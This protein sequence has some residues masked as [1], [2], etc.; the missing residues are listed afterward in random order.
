MT[1][2][3]AHQVIFQ[4]RDAPAAAVVARTLSSPPLVVIEDRIELNIGGGDVM[5][6]EERR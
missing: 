3:D 4:Q 1:F 2:G 5:D 6:L